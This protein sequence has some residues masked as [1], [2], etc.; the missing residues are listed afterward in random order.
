MPGR[1]SAAWVVLAVCGLLDA[2]NPTPLY[3]LT[4]LAVT[5]ATAGLLTF[6]RRDL[7]VL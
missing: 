4:A 5:L 3:V 2:W 1:A 7:P 6:R